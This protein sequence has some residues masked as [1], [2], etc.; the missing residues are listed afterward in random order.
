MEDTADTRNLV[1]WHDGT[2]VAFKIPGQEEASHCFW[3]GTLLVPKPDRQ[4]EVV[5]Y[6]PS[7]RVFWPRLFTH[8]C[9]ACGSGGFV[10]FYRPTW[11]SFDPESGRVVAA[12]G[13]AWCDCCGEFTLYHWERGCILLAGL[14]RTVRACARGA[15]HPD[16]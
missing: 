9:P 16:S 4:G 12:H 2:E 11:E 6:C 3:C 10:H 15:V 5:G 8:L 13:L 7:C 1:T 14:F